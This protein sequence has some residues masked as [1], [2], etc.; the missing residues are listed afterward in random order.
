MP[1]W[2]WVVIAI[3]TFNVGFVLGAVWRA[4][5]ADVPLEVQQDEKQGIDA[6]CSRY[7]LDGKM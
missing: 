6:D 5:F 4:T 2:L 3:L 1:T 7:M